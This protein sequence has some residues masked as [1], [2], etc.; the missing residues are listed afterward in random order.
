MRPAEEVA[1]EWLGKAGVTVDRALML[2]PSLT[3]LIER[4]RN[5][6]GPI[7]KAP[8]DGQVVDAWVP[9]PK[10]PR[11][12]YRIPDVGRSSQDGLWYDLDGKP[13]S[14]QPTHWMPRPKPPEGT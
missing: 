1:L 2:L 14:P 8:R 4:E 12:G 11:R 7:S 10:L 3:A 6:C 9:M 13:L 5:P